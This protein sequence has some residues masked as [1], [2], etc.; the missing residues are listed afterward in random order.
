MTM[1]FLI[2]IQQ[3]A[4]GRVL[5][6]ELVVSITLGSL[7]VVLEGLVPYSLLGNLAVVVTIASLAAASLFV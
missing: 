2:R 4:T 1:F 7:S 6:M 3:G 5:W